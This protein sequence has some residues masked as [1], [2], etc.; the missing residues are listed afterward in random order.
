[1]IRINNMKLKV[2][3]DEK[4]LKS[5]ISKKLKVAEKDIKEIT[6][7]KKSLDAR[8]KTDIYYLYSVNVTLEKGVTY[9][10]SKDVSK[11]TDVSYKLPK[12]K[13]KKIN[14]PII[15]GFG[16]A[17]IFSALILTKLGLN[18]IVFER[19]EDID[20][21]RKCVENFWENGVF[22]EKSNVQFGEG[23]AGTFSD[24]KLTTSI[25]NIRC[26]KVLEEF[27]KHG[28]D[29][30]ILYYNKPHIGTDKLSLI[31]KNIRTYLIEKGCD[32][33]F[34][35]EV[36]DIKIENDKVCGIV[37]NNKDEFLTKNVVLS[38]GHSARDTFYMLKE[39]NVAME[40]KPF[41]VG[42]R[43]EHK[44]E[45]INEAQYGEF[46]K[47]LPPADYKLTYKTESGRNVYTFCMCPGGKVIS[48]S[49][50]NREI[51]VN[52]MSYNNRADDNSNSALL[53]NINTLDFPSDD[54]FS[55][56]DFQ[57]QLEQKAFKIAGENYNAP[58]QLLGDFLNG[59]KTSEIADIT[60]SYKPGYTF[61]E[62]DEIMPKFV[63]ES[64][65]EAVPHFSKKLNGF[66][67]KNAVLTGV[68]T[69]SSSPVRILRDDTHE[70]LN[71]K[72]LYPCGEGCGYA[73]G[74]ISAAVD[75]ITVAEKIFLNNLES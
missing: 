67:Y 57:K 19:G 34:N 26:K 17:G 62:M 10:N 54:V 59:V 43:I 74:I 25:K 50:A 13:L 31:I 58:V 73:G 6:I 65:R 33:H 36:T 2:L 35:S 44:Q 37:V 75:G 52:G 42:F 29:P 30:E 60:P 46:A 69:R 49:S 8:K 38:I 56:I 63:C 61:I 27:V 64:I 32:I 20:S 23:G 71:I 53:V 11:I 21:R 7:Y 70:S 4:I 45:K 5:K 16:P 47:H 39:K 40:K 55:G 66:D 22:N 9:F 24:G 3:E 72:G 51:V 1:M 15:I 12:G 28:A 68:E 41:A 18:P 14:R 48:S